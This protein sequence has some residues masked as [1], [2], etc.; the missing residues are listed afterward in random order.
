M[1]TYEKAVA[2]LIDRYVYAVTKR[3]P[4]AQREDIEK[5]LR[6][7]IDDMLI[8]RTNGAPPSK[9]DAEAVLKEL[10]R[11]SALAAKYRG[12]EQHLIG[13]EYFDIYMMVMKVITIVAASATALAMIIGF[14]A[15][16]PINVFE[17]FGKFLSGVISA[18]IN[19]FAVVTIV[20]A[21]IERFAKHETLKGEDWKPSDLPPV[22]AAKAVIH[23]SEPIVGLVFAVLAI[24]IF[25]AAP[26][27][28]GAGD[29]SNKTFIPV[30]NLDVLYSMLPLIN[31]MFCAGMLKEV[32]R[33]AIGRYD[34]RLAI[35]VAIFNVISLVLTVYIFA[36]PAI[37]N[38]DFMS[39]LST[40]YGWEWAA[41]SEAA[42]VWSIIQK[43][44]VGL[45]IFGIVVDTITT[46][47][48]AFRHSLPRKKV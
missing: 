20:F 2:E 16:P 40:A 10:G 11:P 12:E 34:F 19:A 7:L 29:I 32:A 47:V 33:L 23:K 39:S 36:P 27:L 43:V 17:A 31:I 5:E 6:G 22:P 15:T 26:W 3:L 25:N 4:Q 38:Q 9:E 24:I 21:V 8:A 30:F 1:E 46:A 37:W 14:I 13:P 45:S 42:H 41:T 48:R 18:A 28:F 44:I 35:A